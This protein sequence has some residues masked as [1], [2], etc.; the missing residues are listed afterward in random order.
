[1]KNWKVILP[2]STVCRRKNEIGVWY[3]DI[4]RG[5]HRSQERKQEIARW[6]RGN[7]IEGPS[8]KENE[9]TVHSLF[10]S[11][12]IFILDIVWKFQFHHSNNEYNLS[13]LSAF[14]KLLQKSKSYK[15]WKNLILS[16]CDQH[17]GW[18]S[19]ENLCYVPLRLVCLFYLFGGW[20][21]TACIHKLILNRR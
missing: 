4:A 9:G 5:M 8:R 2:S 19:C 14:S 6:T 3:E 13:L 16:E 17:F 18:S 1:M 12:K 20:L 21:L 15:K 7:G 10:A 11:S